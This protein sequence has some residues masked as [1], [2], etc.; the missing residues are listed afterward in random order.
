[1]ESLERKEKMILQFSFKRVYGKPKFYPENNASQALCAMTE[2]VCLGS[3]QFI[4]VLKLR[5][6]GAVIE[7]VNQETSTQ[8]TGPDLIEVLGL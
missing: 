5:K 8:M 3:E 2:R 7:V 1:M 6:L 4:H